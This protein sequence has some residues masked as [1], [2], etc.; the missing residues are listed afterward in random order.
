MNWS[1]A[2]LDRAPYLVSTEWLAEHL[3]DLGLVLVDCRYYFDGRD[4]LAEYSK[5]HLPG[6]LHLDWSKQLI[7]PAAPHPG[8]FKLPSAE[9]LRETL[10]P[11][12]ISDSSL[13]VGYDDEGGH[14]VSRLVATMAAYGYENVRVLEGGIV[15]WR[16]EGRPLTAD[17]PTPT[18]GHLSFD[19]P[20]SNVFASIDDVLN[21]QGD[22]NVVILDVRRITE[23]TGD[24]VRARHGGRVPWARWAFWQDNLNWEGDRAFKDAQAL[25]ERYEALGVTPDTRVITYCQGGVRAAHSA[26][27]LRLLGHPDV[28]IFDGS[29][30]EW[31]NRD[32]VPIQKG[33]G[34]GR[35]VQDE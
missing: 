18:R 5:E 34:E 30:E 7:D 6:A 1:N 29:W 24:E 33:P 10:E 14:F 13:V 15:K 23:F 22:S 35:K 27:T 12:G 11:L 20:Y 4:G 32:D 3:H 9:R 31:G 28:R 16:V 8:T 25:R 26:L 19:R 17:V 21:S 2:E